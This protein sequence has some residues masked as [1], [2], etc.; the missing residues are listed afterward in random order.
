MVAEKSIVVHFDVKAR[1]CLRD[2]ILSEVA[3]EVPM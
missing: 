2:S 1:G 3:I